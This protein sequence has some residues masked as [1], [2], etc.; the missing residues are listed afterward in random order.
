MLS[1]RSKSRVKEE[2]TEIFFGLVLPLGMLLLVLGVAVS[3]LIVP[4]FIWGIEGV[5]RERQ[6]ELD[7]HPQAAQQV[8]ERCMCATH[9][10]WVERE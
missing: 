10:G 8:E 1:D 5:V 6:C 3:L 7:C 2:V 4:L 9:E